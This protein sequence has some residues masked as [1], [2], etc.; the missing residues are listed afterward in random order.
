VGAVGTW[1]DEAFAVAAWLAAY[2]AAGLLAVWM[3]RGEGPSFWYPPVAIGIACLIHGGLRRWPLILAGDLV[4]SWLQ[5][6]H[7]PVAAGAVAV[8]TT[9]ECVLGAWLL[10]RVSFDPGF[11]NGT[12]S[13]LLVGIVASFAALL[14][15]SA[16]SVMQRLLPT[17][18]PVTWTTWLTWWV[19]D[20]VSTFTLLPAILLGLRRADEGMAAATH[21]SRFERGAVFAIAIAIGLRRAL[22]GSGWMS[23]VAAGWVLGVIPLLWA[24]TRFD[25]RTTALTVA[26]LS[27]AT[28]TGL[29]LGQ[30]PVHDMFSGSVPRLLVVQGNLALV[31][32][33]GMVI[34]H[35]IANE[36]EARRTLQALA[37]ELELRETHLRLAQRAGGIGSWETDLDR[38]AVVWSDTL[39]EMCGFDPAVGAPT[40]E[41]FES[42]IHPESFAE[43]NALRDAVFAGAPHGEAQVRM[44]LPDGREL[45]GR[46]RMERIDR[47]GGA[48]VLGTLTDISELVGRRTTSE[49][50]AGIV[51]SAWDAILTVGPDGIIRTANASAQ[52]LFDPSAAHPLEGRRLMDL[53]PEARRPTKQQRL[54]SAFAGQRLEAEHGEMLR[55]DGAVLPVRISFSPVRDPHQQIVEVAIL[56]GDLTAQHHL[57][58]QLVQSQKMEAVGRLAGGIAHDFNNML[59]VILGFS[60]MARLRAVN[61]TALTQDLDQVVR[62]AERATALTQRLLA[63]SRRAP[64]AP[65]RV[66]LDELMPRLM[67]MLQRLIG[68]DLHM[69]LRAHARA[70][71]VLMDPT[72]LEQILLN[73]VV[74]SRDATPAGGRVVIETGRT[75]I[76]AELRA[77]DSELPAGPV[78]TLA[79]SD[80]GSGMDDATQGRIFEPFFTTK[81]AG[82]GTGLGLSTVLAIVREN[83]GA[84]RVQSE[85]GVGTTFRLFFPELIGETGMEAT[86][87]G[88]SIEPPRGVESVLLVE[89]DALVRDFVAACLTGAGYRVQLAPSAELALEVLAARGSEIQL[90]VTDIV[91]PRQTGIE[92][93]RA[94]LAEREGLPVLLLSGYS[95]ALFGDDLPGRLLTK[96][97]TR[98]ALLFAVRYAIRNPT[99]S[100]RT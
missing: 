70:A 53:V 98:D 39:L 43:W 33:A 69:E 62:A 12:R 60:E 59:T 58:D 52:R 51:S 65:Q 2:V 63:F 42:R 73:L 66:E 7:Q 71:F 55:L 32:T 29:R 80:N 56:C 23:E 25:R 84:V 97:F 38:R 45:W 75:T 100:R 50:L 87:S 14:G 27:I 8:N 68:E 11:R 28:I 26:T 10:L 44:L 64:R 76:D 1:R 77:R 67:P 81:E 9:L 16:G 95:E 17:S 20:A 92:L 54:R 22:I 34:A 21:R 78:V 19:G 86:P 72:Q 91:L 41:V 94:V 36:R 96:P 5:Y 46:V 30:G 15:A 3:Q 48:Y 79:F 49:K 99:R 6:G 24:A 83:G 4:I 74:N 61:D 85:P 47:R 40:T 89:D 18:G 93:A 82:R 13:V 37:A 57:Q 31:A 90:L 35:L 88:L